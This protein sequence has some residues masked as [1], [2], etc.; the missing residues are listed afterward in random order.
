MTNPDVLGMALHPEP[1]DEDEELSGTRT[2][3]HLRALLE[4]PQVAY[5]DL[6]EADAE[7]LRTARGLRAGDVAQMTGGTLEARAEGLLLVL[8]DDE[9]TPPTVAEWPRP[10]AADWVALLAADQAGRDGTRLPDGTVYLTNAEVDAVIDY[11]VDDRGEYMNKPQKTVPGVVRR[12]AETLLTELG[13]LTVA[14][15]G[16]WTL[17]AAAGRYRDPTITYTETP[18]HTR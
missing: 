11:L 2:L 1:A 10:R 8:T 6:P 13:L 3:H 17:A 4:T 16:S 18:E 9:Q 7:A 15:D 14:V 12:D 5:A